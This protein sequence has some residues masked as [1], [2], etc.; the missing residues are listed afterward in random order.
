MNILLSITA[1][2]FSMSISDM[3]TNKTIVFTQDKWGEGDSTLCWW[4]DA[5]SLFWFLTHSLLPVIKLCF[6]C[7]AWSWWRSVILVLCTVCVLIREQVEQFL[8]NNYSL[9]TCWINNYINSEIIQQKHKSLATF[10]L[11]IH[12]YRGAPSF[13]KILFLL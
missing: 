3:Q 7:C 2:S 4:A 10:E 8:E 6:T 11:G 12:F 1:I 13:V 5:P 9:L